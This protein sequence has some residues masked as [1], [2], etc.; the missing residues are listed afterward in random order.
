MRATYGISL[1]GMTGLMVVMALATAGAACSSTN[2]AAPS[3]VPSIAAASFELAGKVV[4][5]G[6]AGLAGV[7]ITL[8][9]GEDGLRHAVTDDDG[10]FTIRNLEAGEWTA[11][12]KCKGYEDRAVQIVIN[13]NVTFTFDLIAAN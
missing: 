5:A 7:E 8:S 3:A 9:R 6:G 13:G 11:V 10:Q 12:L 1:K 4:G 2:P